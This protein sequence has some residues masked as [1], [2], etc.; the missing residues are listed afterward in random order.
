MS[1]VY[2]VLMLVAWCAFCAFLPTST[3]VMLAMVA[4]GTIFIDPFDNYGRKH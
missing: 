2:R 4:V 1:T 3:F